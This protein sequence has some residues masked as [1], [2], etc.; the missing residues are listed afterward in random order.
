MKK[1]LFVGCVLLCTVV[2]ATPYV[3][4]VVAKQRYPWNCKADISFEVVGDLEADLPAGQIAELSVAMTDRTTGKT[5]TPCYLSGDIEPTAG[6]HHVVW[7]LTGLGGVCST[8]AV[9]SVSYLTRNAYRVIDISKGSTAEQY[10]VSILRA[11]P[12][13]GWGDEYKTDKIV[14]RC[15]DGTNG[16]YYA[17]I[18]EI[19]QAQWDKVMGGTSSSTNPKDCVSYNSIRGDADTYNWP[20]TTDV[21]ATSFIGK[22]RQKTGLTMLDL[23]SEAEWEFAARAGV[24]T[25]WLCGDSYQWLWDYAWFKDDS[26]HPVGG[27]RANAWELY[28][29]LGNVSE[30]CLD[31]YSSDGSSRVVRGGA[32][33]DGSDCCTL[34]WRNGD[35]PSSGVDCIGFRLFCRPESN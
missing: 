31:R 1:W 5:Y 17:G 16:V 13:D 26:H 14:L 8:E 30:W 25:T 32:A 22:L 33:S 35:S 15:I 6:S 21:D 24:T 28:D 9:F 23:P 34:S 7:D 3:T 19:T 10:P 2:N 12:N 11:V 20:T 4:N 18:F 27:R 29:V